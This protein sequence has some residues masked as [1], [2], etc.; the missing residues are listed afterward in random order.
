MSDSA[1]RW[2]LDTSVSVPLIMAAHDQHQ[3]VNDI[4]GERVVELAAHAFLETYAVV[5]RL[6]GDARLEVGDAARLIA[7]RFGTPVTLPSRL[8]TALVPR[9]ARLG[10][11]GGATYDAL[12]AATAAHAGA[13]LITRDRRAVTTYRLLAIDVEMLA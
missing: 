5:T 9:L 6:P 10:I 1:A 11:G 4:I 12:I 3:R 8:T 13:S 2:F 7:A